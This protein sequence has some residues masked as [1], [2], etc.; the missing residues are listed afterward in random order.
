MKRDDYLEKIEQ[1]RQE[2]QIEENGEDRIRSRRELR[3]N[4]RRNGSK[5]PAKKSSKLLTTMFGIFILIPVGVLIY[6]SAF[7]EPDTM[8]TATKDNQ[9][10]MEVNTPEKDETKSDEIE[11]PIVEDN[12]ETAEVEQ[13][14]ADDSVAAPAEPDENLESAPAEEQPEEVE[15]PSAEERT[16]VVAPGETLF[17]IAMNYYGSPDGVET[18]KD[19]NGLSSNEISAGQT[20]R[21]P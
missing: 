1:H 6:V 12:N 10:K 18:I 2:I 17:R 20:L 16:H 5:K 13:P 4:G 14:N 8:E 19:A 11:S 7:Y 21:I 3:S 15:T 9:F